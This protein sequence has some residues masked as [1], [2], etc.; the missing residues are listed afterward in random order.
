MI[1]TDW[2]SKWM[3]LTWRYD[4]KVYETNDEIGVNIYL[5]V[6]SRDFKGKKLMGNITLNKFVAKQDH[7]VAMWEMSWK[8]LMEQGQKRCLEEMGF[9][10]EKKNLLRIISRVGDA[11]VRDIMKEAITT[12]MMQLTYPQIKEVAEDI[13]TIELRWV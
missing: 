13:Y 5:M 8:R 9:Y 7:A 12:A 1:T 3:E 4:Y 2:I 10:E 6:V 11:G